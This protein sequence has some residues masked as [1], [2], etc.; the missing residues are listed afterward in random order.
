MF[1]DANETNDARLY[2]RISE[3]KHAKRCFSLN[4]GTVLK[5]L[6]KNP[7][8]CW[9]LN[10]FYFYSLNTSSTNKELTCLLSAVVFQR[11]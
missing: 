11:R 8:F 6:N 9:L 10:T 5:N 4:P 3:V 7:V 1:S 2:S